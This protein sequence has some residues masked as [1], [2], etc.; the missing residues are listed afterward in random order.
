MTLCTGQNLTGSKVDWKTQ[1]SNSK[2]NRNERCKKKAI[3]DL[4]KYNMR[5]TDNRRSDTTCYSLNWH[6]DLKQHKREYPTDHKG[7]NVFLVAGNAKYNVSISLTNMSKHTNSSSSSHNVSANWRPS[8][9]TLQGEKECKITSL[10]D[11]ERWTGE[12]DVWFCLMVRTAQSCLI[13]WK[14]TCK[15]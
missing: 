1:V 12:E 9:Y 7:S 4:K 8:C 10:R 2:F 14:F 11:G 5:S 3:K 13:K 6:M 15:S